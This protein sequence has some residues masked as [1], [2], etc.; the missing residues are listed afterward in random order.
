MHL[1]S[2][3]VGMYLLNV[4]FASCTHSVLQRQT[5]CPKWKE[6]ET[7]R[8]SN[9]TVTELWQA[10][11]SQW[12]LLRG[13]V[14][15]NGYASGVITSRLTWMRIVLSVMARSVPSSLPLSAYLCFKAG[16]SVSLPR[17]WVMVILCSAILWTSF[18]VKAIRDRF[19]Q[20]RVNKSRTQ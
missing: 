1:Y 4:S 14:G 13:Q 5:S 9:I 7:W 6:L 8:N 20:S 11:F 2:T 15:S 16:S 12:T 17:D 19:C 10:A 18:C 3:A